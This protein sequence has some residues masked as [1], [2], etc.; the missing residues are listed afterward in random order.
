[1]IQVKSSGVYYSWRNRPPID[2]INLEKEGVLNEENGC[3]SLKL[4][5]DQLGISSFD[6]SIE[7][8]IKV[9]YHSGCWYS[10]YVPPSSDDF[11]M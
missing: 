9:S 3:H 7:K 5:G 4:S 1:M 8:V 2:N 11:V 6:G 10:K